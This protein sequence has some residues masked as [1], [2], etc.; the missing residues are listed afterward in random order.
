MIPKKALIAALIISVFSH[1]LILTMTG[2][3]PA[4]VERPTGDTI[5]VELTG[6]PVQPEENPLESK[7]PPMRLTVRE[8][9]AITDKEDTVD[10]DDTESKY[11][12]YL[13]R[14]KQ[15]IETVWS[16]PDDALHQ[17]L[18]GTNMLRFTVEHDGSL[19]GVRLL[20]RSGNNSLDLGSI[21]AVR[22]AA[23]FDPIPGEMK[24]NRLHI[25]ATFDYRI[26]D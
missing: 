13:M 11:A 9:P 24:L 5:T 6:K 8:M 18:A 25:I 17:K 4:Y 12:P 26:V 3:I 19:V 10:L 15:R 20:T 7:V 14:I 21:R 22:S 2:F 23:P 16:Y 1:V